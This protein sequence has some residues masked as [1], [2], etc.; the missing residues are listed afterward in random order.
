MHMKITFANVMFNRLTLFQAKW[1]NTFFFLNVLPPLLK[2]PPL[3]K[4]KKFYQLV[5]P[6]CSFPPLNFML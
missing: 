6:N 3:L 5:H 2:K 4:L 1:K